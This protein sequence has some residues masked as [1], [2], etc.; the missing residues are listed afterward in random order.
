[1]STSYIQLRKSNNVT[2]MRRDDSPKRMTVLVSIIS[3]RTGF[4]S[5]EVVGVNMDGGMRD[6]RFSSSRTSIDAHMQTKVNAL[7]RQMALSLSDLH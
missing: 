2:Q 5:S 6:D 7:L 3:D 4:T 1:M